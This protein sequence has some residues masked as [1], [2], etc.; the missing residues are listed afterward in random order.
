[1]AAKSLGE[2]VPT[3][4]G[5]AALLRGE[6][7]LVRE[8]EEEEEEEE[9]LDT[10]EEEELEEGEECTE[11]KAASVCFSKAA[12]HSFL[13]SMDSLFINF[14]NTSIAVVGVA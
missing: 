5:V 6:E 14:S 2:V 1:M 12:N 11:G 9:E 4:T 13:S 3:T 8:E 10:K 7:K